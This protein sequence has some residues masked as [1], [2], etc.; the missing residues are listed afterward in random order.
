MKRHALLAATAAVLTLGAGAALADCRED[1]ARMQGGIAKDGSLAPLSESAADATPQTGGGGN[2]AEPTDQGEA[3]AKDGSEEP[4]EMDTSLAT[5]AQD[6]Q[7][8]QAGGATAAA[9]AEGV[10][11]DMTGRDAALARAEAAL[12]A[13]DEA[14]C[15]DALEAAEN[16]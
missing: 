12:A 7:A 13:G 14:G 4:L 9:Q 1:L 5:S 8:Q 3:I 16:S 10:E 11:G 2:A 15:L 6:A